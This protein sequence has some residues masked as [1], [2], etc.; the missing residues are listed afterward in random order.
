MLGTREKIVISRPHI[1]IFKYFQGIFNFQGLQENP[2]YSSTFLACANPALRTGPV[3]NVDQEQ[4][5]IRFSLMICYITFCV[6]FI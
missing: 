1:A 4:S 6:I 2:L 5:V 3:N